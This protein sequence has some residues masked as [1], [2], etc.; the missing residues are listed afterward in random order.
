MMQLT[1]RTECRTAN[2]TYPKGGVSCSTDSFVVNQTLVFQIK[3]RGKSPTLRAA[4][5]RYMQLLQLDFLSVFNIYL[6]LLLFK[7][8]QNEKST[9]F[10]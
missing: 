6:Y 10:Y 4:A 5:N 3:F 1:R 2:S 8:K 9:T 7:L